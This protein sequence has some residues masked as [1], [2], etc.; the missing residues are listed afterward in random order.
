MT[1]TQR[2]ARETRI[3]DETI[4]A[5]DYFSRLVGA[6]EGGDWRY[7]RDKLR[8]LQATLADLAL[9]LDRK[10]PA[11]GPPVAAFV[12]EYS[13]HTRIGRALYG[14]NPTPQ[15]ISPKVAAEVLHHFGA[16]GG[17]E[18]SGF[19]RSLIL[20]IAQADVPNRARLARAFP[21]YVAAV[22]SAQATEDGV[23]E[24]QAIAAGDDA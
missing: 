14:S 20:A 24:L 10:G 2:T 3:G 8:Q 5:I 12:A 7:S 11:A 21:D 16:D 22:T 18:P 9:Q 13:Q 6:I 15:T 4:N 23:V 17:R 19:R 1:T